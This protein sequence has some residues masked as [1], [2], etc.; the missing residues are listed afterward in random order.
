VNNRGCIDFLNALEDAD[1]KFAP[2]LDSEVT[3][4]GVRHF[5]KE[6]LDQIRA[7]CT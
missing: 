6:H 7:R 2:R 5:S 4:K 1:A 3:Q